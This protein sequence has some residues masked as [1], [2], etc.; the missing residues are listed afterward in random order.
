M[1]GTNIEKARALKRDKWFEKEYDIPKYPVMERDRKKLNFD[2]GK[3]I[4][5][6]DD[7]AALTRTGKP[8]YKKK[9]KK[10]FKNPYRN[11]VNNDDD[12]KTRQQGKE[13]QE[14]PS[15]IKPSQTVR[16]SKS[17][18]KS[19][20]RCEV[21]DIET[22]ETNSVCILVLS[23]DG[24]NK[25]TI[26]RVTNGNISKI[27]SCYIEGEMKISSLQDV[28]KNVKKN[29]TTSPACRLSLRV[30]PSDAKRILALY[31]KRVV[32][33][34]IS[35]SVVNISAIECIGENEATARGLLLGNNNDRTEQMN[36]AAGA[37][38]GTSDNDGYNII[39]TGDIKSFEEEER[40]RFTLGGSKKKRTLNGISSTSFDTTKLSGSG[41]LLSPQ[42]SP[43]LYKHYHASHLE[44]A[45]N[46]I[47]SFILKV[48]DEFEQTC[49]INSMKNKD[50]EPVISLREA[51]EAI[52][53]LLKT[54][55][56][57]AGD[58]VRHFMEEQEDKRYMNYSD[59]VKLFS[60]GFYHIIQARRKKEEEFIMV[61]EEDDTGDNN[62]NTY[63][64]TDVILIDEP[65]SVNH[66]I[67]DSISA[68]VDD[69]Y[70][71]TMETELIRPKRRNQRSSKK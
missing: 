54:V 61:E 15:F 46:M 45:L 49:D 26:E 23:I 29:D 42:S 71:I 31:G 53:R 44:Q 20:L 24:A 16:L 2:Q 47:G 3:D 64:R 50:D 30:S 56:P 6:W 40:L 19:S 60:F 37:T 13:K 41:A 10:K 38:V 11:E 36:K 34:V 48:N 35:G 59:F 43:Q 39:G 8:S 55:P 58:I 25:K 51:T 63:G 5:N 1:H 69:D 4:H 21:H 52:C 70:D 17:F 68:M 66:A 7:L 57:G 67:G 18:D 62:N 9:N 27:V 28:V 22:K 12:E 65:V 32:K 33:K 14:Q